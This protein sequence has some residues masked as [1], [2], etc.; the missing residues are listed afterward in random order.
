VRGD[1]TVVFLT[2]TILG[3]RSPLVLGCSAA[4]W[5]SSP[6]WGR[7]GALSGGGVRTVL[8]STTIPGLEG[9][10]FMLVVIVTWTVCKTWRRSSSCRASWRQ[11]RPASLM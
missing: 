9:L 3:V 6:T 10:F 4:C 2:A 7:D 11:P 1:G 8:S 5:S